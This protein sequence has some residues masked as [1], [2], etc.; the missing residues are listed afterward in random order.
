[1]QEPDNKRERAEISGMD[2]G[3]PP[4]SVA[5]EAVRRGTNKP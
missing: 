2:D 4:K 1:M 3:G 5:R